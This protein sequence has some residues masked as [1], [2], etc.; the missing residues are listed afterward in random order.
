MATG[1]TTRHIQEAPQNSRNP[2][3]TP[4]SASQH[5]GGLRKSLQTRQICS[6]SIKRLDCQIWP[7]V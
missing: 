6:Y 7:V 5:G 1:R 4:L 3:N 2:K